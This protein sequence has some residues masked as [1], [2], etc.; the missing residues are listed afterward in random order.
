MVRREN[1][2]TQKYYNVG[3]VLTVNRTIVK[4]DP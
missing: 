4:T 3:T 1:E 2:K